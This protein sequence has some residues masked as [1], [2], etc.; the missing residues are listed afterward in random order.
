MLIWESGIEGVCVGGGRVAVGVKVGGSCLAVG[1]SVGTIVAV[2]LVDGTMVAVAGARL[3]EVV[4]I[5]MAMVN[6]ASRLF[7]GCLKGSSCTDTRSTYKHVVSKDAN[8]PST[9]PLITHHQNTLS[10]RCPSSM[11]TRLCDYNIMSLAVA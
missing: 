7:I 2:N 4:V 5:R 10:E 6:T 9:V 3:H 1:V 8:L 11:D